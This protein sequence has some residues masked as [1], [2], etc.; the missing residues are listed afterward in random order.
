MTIVV[1]ARELEGARTGV[2]RY[3]DEILH[4]LAGLPQTAGLRVT[5]CSMTPLDTTRYAGLTTRNVVLPGRGLSWEQLQL[6]RLLRVE[7]PTLLF[8]PGYTCPLVTDVPTVLVVHDVSF[9]AHPEW[10]SWQEG[11]R[12]RTIG[13]L[14]ARRAAAVVTVSQFSRGEIEAHWDVAPSRITVIPNGVTRLGVAHPKAHA[15]PTVLFVGSV[16][17]RRHVPALIDA[18]AILVRR[19]YPVRLDIVGDNRTRPA[20]DLA[21]YAARAG[22]GDRVTCRAYVSDVELAE[23]YARASSF[24]FVSDYEGFGLTP[25][26]ALA[27]GLPIV[28]LDHPATRE[29]YEDAATFLADAEPATIASGL[30]RSLFD[31]I[32]RR[33]VL[34]HADTV[35]ERYSWATAATTLWQVFSRVARCTRDGRP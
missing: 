18:V 31:P 33:R 28:V 13:R 11:A 15:D 4:A 27:S 8:S 12:R 7:R 17:T 32:E 22:V 14:A 30:E 25:L 19:G 1:D 10:F 3:L 35:L 26:E 5:L 21:A 2:G 16:F 6:P 34:E 9:A 24:A 23:A 20:V 29:V